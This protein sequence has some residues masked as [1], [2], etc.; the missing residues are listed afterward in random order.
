MTSSA[1]QVAAGF[2][3]ALLLAAAIGVGVAWWVHRRTTLS[4]WNVYLAWIV[5]AP[6]AI[7][8]VTSGRLIAVAG[9]A[10]LFVGTTAAAMAARRWRLGALGAGGELRQFE[11][12]RVM[13][14]NARRRPEPG[15]RV[16]IAGQGE[17]VRER[18]W[19]QHVPA[20]PMTHDGRAPIPLA[21]GMHLFFVGATGSGKTTSARRWLLA[22]GLDPT[23]TT[24]LVVLDPKGDDALEQDLRAI[25]AD[26]GRPFVLFDPFD[27]ATDRWNPSGPTTP[28]RSSRAL[29]RRSKP[30]RTPRP[31]TTAA[32]CAYTSA[33]S[34][35][36]C[37][38]PT[39]GRSACQCC[40]A[41]LSAR[42][43]TKSPR[44]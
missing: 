3:G 23:A 11:R 8:G 2:A 31:A 18:A 35:K 26:R 40:C 30:T 43:S 33:S 42:D 1:P 5:A 22:R 13:A 32:Y 41:A 19:P 44:L 37:T 7:V 9:S 14:W 17:L 4:A 25:A 36:P 6:V 24:R 12:A 27:A 15:Q 38:P 21:E 29:S 20:L 16:Y 28:A 39:A 34:P 10:V